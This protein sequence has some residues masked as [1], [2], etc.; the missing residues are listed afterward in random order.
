MPD[1]DGF[2]AILDALLK[3]PGRLVYQLH[4]KSPLWPC[5]VLGAIALVCLTLYGLVAGSFSGGVQ[6]WAAPV[7]IVLGTFLSALICLPSLYIFSCLS[8]AEARPGPLC[9][10][11]LASI[12]LNALLLVSFTPVAWVFSQSTES[13]AF[14][15]A[16]H[17][18]FWIISLFFGL[19]M[20]KATAAYIGAKDKEYL[21]IWFMIF[22]LV[23][24]QMTTALRPIIGQ[25][26]TLLPVEKKFFLAHWMESLKR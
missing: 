14:M 11:L 23:C 2:G 12:G 25:A 3:H 17:L 15:G 22:L 18:A 8:G 26:P 21:R 13:V 16:M 9:G 6:W 1:G 7:K 20:I 5:V 4:Q 10:G 19:R 24:L